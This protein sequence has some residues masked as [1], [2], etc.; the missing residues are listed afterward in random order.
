MTQIE[1]DLI[2]G[3]VDDALDDLNLACHR[4][5]IEVPHLYR[6]LCHGCRFARAM[7]FRPPQRPEGSNRTRVR[8]LYPAFTLTN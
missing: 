4:C 7:T 5:G 2:E 6:G 3:L 1:R 8:V